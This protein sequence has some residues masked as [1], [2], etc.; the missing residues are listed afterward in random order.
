[1]VVE[2]VCLLAVLICRLGR[3]ETGLVGM[4]KEVP[5][6]A[7]RA[8]LKATKVLLFNEPPAGVAAP[9]YPERTE[10]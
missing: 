5:A 7:E 9:N 2:G 6:A 10:K 1:M 8:F 4:L 3:R